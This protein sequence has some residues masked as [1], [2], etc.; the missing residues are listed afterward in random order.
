MDLLFVGFELSFAGASG[1][2]SLL[3]FFDFCS[4]FSGLIFSSFLCF[5]RCFFQS[6]LLS[7]CRSF[8][9]ICLFL[10]LGSFCGS[11]FKD[12]D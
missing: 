5:S 10:P 4:K 11:W 2:G 7:C 8:F 6:R 9:L 12:L 1:G 3:Q